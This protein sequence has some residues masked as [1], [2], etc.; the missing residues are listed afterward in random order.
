MKLS[1]LTTKIGILAAVGPL[2]AGAVALADAPANTPGHS[3]RPVI[4]LVH[5]AWAEAFRFPSV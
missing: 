1:T 3:I 4:V 2:A 5:G